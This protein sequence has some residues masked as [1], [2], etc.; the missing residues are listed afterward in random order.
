MKNIKIHDVGYDEEFDLLFVSSADCKLTL[1]TTEERK[2]VKN[3]TQV[4]TGDVELT[5]RLLAKQHNVLF[6]G[7][8]IGTIRV[9]LWPII[10]RK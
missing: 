2:Q 6:A 9:Y 10:R 1:Y 5:T 3:Y 8:N 4:S 7:T